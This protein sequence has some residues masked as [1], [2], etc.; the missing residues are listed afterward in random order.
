MCGGKLG[1]ESAA[2]GRLGPGRW[3]TDDDM[4]LGAVTLEVYYRYLPLY[5]LDGEL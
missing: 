3:P 5:K 4:S 1:P 2:S